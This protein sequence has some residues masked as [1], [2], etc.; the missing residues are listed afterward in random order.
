[1]LADYRGKAKLRG[2]LMTWLNADLQ[3]DLSKD[4][5]KYPEFDAATIADLRTSLGLFLDDVLWS[6]SADYRQLLLSRRGLFE[7]PVG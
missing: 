4:P 5:E 7:R 3:K 6:G 1:M 2:F